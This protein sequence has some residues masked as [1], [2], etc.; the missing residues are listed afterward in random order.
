MTFRELLKGLVQQ[1]PGGLVAMLVGMDGIPVDQFPQDEDLL[2]LST[3]TVEFER[4]LAETRKAVDALGGEAL[5]SL[6]ELIVS[7]TRYHLLFRAVDEEYV[8]VMAL[9]PQGFLGKA[10]YL[11]AC[12]LQDIR[13]EL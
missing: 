11:V 3:V 12:L 10:R 7:T 2:D 5:G 4:V 1:T 6:E 8:L 13:R 9:D